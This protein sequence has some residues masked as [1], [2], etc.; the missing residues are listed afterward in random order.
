MPIDPQIRRRL[1]PGIED[2]PVA[3]LLGMELSGVG[4]GAATYLLRVDERFHNPMGS[5][6]GGVLGDLADLSMGVAV[7]STLE[8]DETFTTLEFKI[9]FLRP[10]FQGVLRANGRVTFRGKTIAYTDCEIASDKGKL[11]ARA[12]GTHM[13]LKRAGEEDPFHHRPRA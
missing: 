2:A 1:P 12:T 5:L 9:N 13:V 11:V 3:K 7:A 6:H 8:G 10:F 4:S